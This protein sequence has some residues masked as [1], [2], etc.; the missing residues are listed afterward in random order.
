MNVNGI[1][2]FECGPIN[3]PSLAVSELKFYENGAMS[4]LVLS[5][6][7]CIFWWFGFQTMTLI[8]ESPR[9]KVLKRRLSARPKRRRLPE[10]QERKR[11]QLLGGKSR[12]PR[13]RLQGRILKNVVRN[14]YDGRLLNLLVFQGK[15]VQLRQWRDTGRW[16]R[17][18]GL[19]AHQE[20]QKEE[21]GQE[22][23]RL[24]PVL[25]HTQRSQ[26]KK[27]EVCPC[28]CQSVKWSGANQKTR[29]VQR[30]FGWRGGGRRGGAATVLP[31]PYQ[32]GSQISSCF[33]E[34]IVQ[35]EGRTKEQIE[36]VLRSLG[37]EYIVRCI[38]ITHEQLK[39]LWCLFV[40][41]VWSWRGGGGGVWGR[42]WA[43]LHA[44]KR[45]LSSVQETGQKAAPQAQTSSNIRDG[46]RE[47]QSI[48]RPSKKRVQ[49]S[50]NQ[51]TFVRSNCSISS[52]G[53]NP[54]NTFF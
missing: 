44:Q 50:F 23:H 6:K 20:V 27:E 22:E 37:G 52:T 7:A 18:G 25:Q 24:W 3:N 28:Y 4:W 14:L 53:M 17:W 49:S 13:H 12:L 5:K 33:Q 34:V 16:Q 36:Q 26:R 2:I 19:H 32:E 10:E 51:G 45:S 39:Y 54:K 43:S 48:E 41:T 11:K 35:E 8:T 1:V 42:W 30:G 9:R 21:S 29:Q 31:T 47:H 46:H 15:E 40:L 38:L